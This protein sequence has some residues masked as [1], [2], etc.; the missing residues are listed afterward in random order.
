MNQIDQAGALRLRVGIEGFKKNVLK[1]TI[2]AT[3]CFKALWIKNAFMSL[4]LV[5]VNHL[6][7]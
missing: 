1:L 3:Q 6:H 5:E 7:F 4:V 2:I